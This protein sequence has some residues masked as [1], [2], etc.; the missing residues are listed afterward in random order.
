MRFSPELLRAVRKQC[1]V[2]Q[3]TLAARSGHNRVTVFNIEH[4]IKPTTVDTLADFALVLGVDTTEF[5]EDPEPADYA[6]EDFA[7]ALHQRADD[8]VLALADALA[9]VAAERRARRRA[10][11]RD[12]AGAA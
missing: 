1:G 10:S 4:G 11:D 7:V 8:Y 12:K 9:R 2:S 3:D 5:Y 6:A